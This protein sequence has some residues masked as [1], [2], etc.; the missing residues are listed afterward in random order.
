MSSYQK[1]S[2]LDFAGLIVNKAG[3]LVSQLDHPT[4]DE[5]WDKDQ[6]R[7]HRVKFTDGDDIALDTWLAKAAAEGISVKGSRF[8]DALEQT[9]RES[10][11]LLSLLT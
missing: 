8:W 2:G 10:S 4:V 6:Q 7:S 9:V 5:H 1:P 3:R 11:F